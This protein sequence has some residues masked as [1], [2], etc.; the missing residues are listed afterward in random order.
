MHQA[1]EENGGQPADLQLSVA[2]AECSAAILLPLCILAPSRLHV[3]KV[4]PTP[5]HICLFLFSLP[6]ARAAGNALT[7]PLGPQTEPR[8]TLPV[9]L[10]YNAAPPRLAGL[11]DCL[12]RS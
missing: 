9:T 11:F 7:Q 12:P 10:Y 1:G 2:L 4:M 3:H 8:Y 6:T 5:R